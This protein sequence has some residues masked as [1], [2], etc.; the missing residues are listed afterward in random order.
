MDCPTYAEDLDI[1]QRWLEAIIAEL[2]YR[3]SIISEEAKPEMIQVLKAQAKES[4]MTAWTG[5]ND[6]AKLMIAPNISCYNA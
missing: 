2:A 3:L 5:D 6:G 4:L 1:P